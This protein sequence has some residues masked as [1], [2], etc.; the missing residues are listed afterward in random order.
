M[1]EVFPELG[2]IYAPG[3]RT[4]H[5]DLNPDSIA[6]NH[7][8]ALG[9]QADPK[10]TLQALTIVLEQRLSAEELARAHNRS[11]ALASAKAA[12]LRLELEADAQRKLQQR[13]GAP[14]GGAM[15]L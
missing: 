11:S 8:V 2:N 10:A 7:A 4:I 15:H 1:P 5:I 13:V 12:R 3:S 9:L 6:K 14:L